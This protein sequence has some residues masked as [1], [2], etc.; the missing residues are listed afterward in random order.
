MAVLYNHH[1]RNRHK[2]QFRFLRFDTLAVQAYSGDRSQQSVNGKLLEDSKIHPSR[3]WSLSLEISLERFEQGFAFGFTH[4]HTRTNPHVVSGI[5]K[6]LVF[7]TGPSYKD[8]G[9]NL[10]TKQDFLK[11]WISAKTRKFKITI[12]KNLFLMTFHARYWKHF[13][14]ANY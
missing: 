6:T 7:E 10:Q 14:Q 12:S 3:T 13:W 11:V 8:S 9:A 4:F 5:S 2:F 1:W